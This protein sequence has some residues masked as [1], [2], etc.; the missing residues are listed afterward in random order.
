MDIFPGVYFGPRAGG[1]VRII[2]F[3]YNLDKKTKKKEQI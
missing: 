1:K 2:G 3:Y